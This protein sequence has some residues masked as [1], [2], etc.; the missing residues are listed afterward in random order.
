MRTPPSAIVSTALDK[1]GRIYALVNN[2][3]VA[4]RAG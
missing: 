4:G 2:S 3:G 1:L